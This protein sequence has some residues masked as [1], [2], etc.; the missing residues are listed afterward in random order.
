[1]F[2]SCGANSLIA[3]EVEIVALRIPRRIVGVEVVVSYTTQLSVS[4]TPDM[5][6]RKQIL[7]GH[8]EGEEVSSRRPGVIA[9]LTARRICNFNDL[10]IGESQHV[11]LAVFVAERDSFSVRRPLRLVTHR[12]AAAA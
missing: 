2:E 5:H 10:A 4:R 9:N 8:R 12:G 11:Q 6:R 1:M 7:V 3:E